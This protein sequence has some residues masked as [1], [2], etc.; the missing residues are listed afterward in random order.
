M[1]SSRHT[2]T[3]D[4]LVEALDKGPGQ[5]GYLHVLRSAQLPLAEL[6]RHSTWNEKHYTRNCI[7]QREA[8]ELLL[9]CYEQGQRTSI[10]DHDSQEAYVHAVSGQV[11]EERFEPLA[12]GLRQ[13]SSVVLRQESFSYLSNG[14]S[15]HRCINPGPG[16]AMT[17]NLYARPLRKWRVYDE[18]YGLWSPGPTGA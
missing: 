6:E 7:A 1:T 4:E 5:T 12:A 10:H 18:R 15:I 11:L 8:Y 13:V 2:I 14:H 3:L 16:R 9:I 17:L